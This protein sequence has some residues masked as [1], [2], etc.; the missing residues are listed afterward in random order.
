MPF[1]VA[2]P[3]SF[4]DMVIHCL[5]SSKGN[6]S[7]AL[8][9]YFGMEACEEE[10][11]PNLPLAGRKGLGGVSDVRGVQQPSREPSKQR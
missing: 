10:I 7:T 2:V 1:G 11:N 3:L 6:T 8:E 9:G 5:S 4:G